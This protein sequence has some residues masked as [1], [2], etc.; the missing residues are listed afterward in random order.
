MTLHLNILQLRLQISNGTNPGVIT[1]IFQKERKTDQDQGKGNEKAK[2]SRLFR[3][4]TCP[5]SSRNDLWVIYGHCTN[6]E[7]IETRD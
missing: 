6:P 3:S 2:L 5:F 7:M 1:I 4:I